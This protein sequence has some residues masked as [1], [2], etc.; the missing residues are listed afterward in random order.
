MMNVTYPTL[1]AASGLIFLNQIFVPHQHEILHV[2]WNHCFVAGLLYEGHWS[3][4]TFRLLLARNGNLLSSLWRY[5]RSLNSLRPR[6]NRRH[7]ADD[8]FKCIFENE[9]EWI[10]PRISLKFVPKVRINNIP[11]LVHITAWCRPGDKS[12]SEPMMVNLLT[13]ICVTR[14]QS[15][16]RT[17]LFEAGGCW[18]NKVVGFEFECMERSSLRLPHIYCRVKR[19]TENWKHPLIMTRIPFLLT[20]INFNPNTTSTRT[21]SKVWDGLSYPFPTSTVAPSKFNNR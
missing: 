15:L 1:V 19:S 5:L 9:N 14:P 2:Y 3:L 16:I 21:P 20:W 13:H 7:F 17:P 11:A 12:L 10:S 18:H 8:I 4:F 6:P